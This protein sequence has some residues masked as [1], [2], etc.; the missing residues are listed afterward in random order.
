MEPFFW[1]HYR[2]GAEET[3]TSNSVA[4]DSRTALQNRMLNIPEGGTRC[5][6]D[7]H[8]AGWR[9]TNRK[10][11]RRRSSLPLP[12]SSYSTTHPPTSSF[13]NCCR[14]CVIHF[15]P[16][17]LPPLPPIPL[18]PLPPPLP[19]F[20]IFSFSFFFVVVVI[21][22]VGPSLH[23]RLDAGQQQ[24]QVDGQATSP[25]L[26]VVVFVARGVEA[27]GLGQEVV[28]YVQIYEAVLGMGAEC[29]SPTFLLYIHIS[30]CV[31]LYF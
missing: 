31:L 18:P 16:P 22:P 4:W 25:L 5:G 20:L 2:P 28:R 12:P 11:D 26:L 23:A 30:V 10:R 27:S 8:S 6:S 14:L 7:P 21:L 9:T 17:P 1:E 15:P 19:R 24:G 29:Y 13:M 3:Q